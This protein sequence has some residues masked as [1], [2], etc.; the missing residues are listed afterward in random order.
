MVA[1]C[2]NSSNK[3]VRRLKRVFEMRKQG[4]YPE[5]TGPDAWRVASMSKPGSSHLVHVWLA[6]PFT[7]VDAI[8]AALDASCSCPSRVECRHI[9]AVRL[10][11]NRD[12]SLVFELEKAVAA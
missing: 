4:I 10:E 12:S 5:Q 1:Q 7:H 9:L 2:G 11:Y 8:G 6:R 3:N